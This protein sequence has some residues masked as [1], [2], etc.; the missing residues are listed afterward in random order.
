MKILK[1]VLYGI[2]IILSI[3][4]ALIFGAC[5]TQTG[6][7]LLIF[8]TSPILQHYGININTQNVFGVLAK[9]RINQFV[10]TQESEEIFVRQFQ[11]DWHPGKLIFQDSLSIESLSINKVLIH[12]IS[13]KKQAT[14]STK[15]FSF[16]ELEETLDISLPIDIS[17]K[18]ILIK[19]IN[20]AYDSTKLNL[21]KLQASLELDDRLYFANITLNGKA[22]DAVF[23]ADFGVKKVFAHAKIVSK[24]TDAPFNLEMNTDG[25]FADYRINLHT[26]FASGEYTNT[27]DLNAKGDDNKLNAKIS[28]VMLDNKFSGNA[29]IDFAHH[30]AW[31]IKLHSPHFFIKNIKTYFT[32]LSLQCNQSG[33]VQ[34][35]T[36]NVSS[37][38]ESGKV[39]INFVYKPISNIWKLEVITDKLSILN[40]PNSNLTL[41]SKISVIKTDVMRINGNINIP[42]AKV[43]LDYLKAKFASEEDV[44]FVNAKNQ[45]KTASLLAN[46]QGNIKV[47]FGNNVNLYNDDIN[48]MLS[49]SLHIIIKPNLPVVA[50]GTL[51]LKKGTYHLQTKTFTFDDGKVLFINSPISNPAL[52]ITAIYKLPPSFDLK[53]AGKTPTVIGVKVTG[54]AHNPSLELFST[55]AMSKNDILSYM[56]FGNKVKDLQS[57]SS[58]L[59]HKAL[60]ML[61]HGT[62]SLLLSNVKSSTQLAQLSVG[63]INTDNDASSTKDNSAVFIGNNLTNRIYVSYGI[64]LF[65]HQHVFTTIYK[66]NH[67]WRVKG[68]NSNDGVGVD[69]LYLINY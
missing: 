46:A 15:K 10:I 29:S 39:N 5:Y 2:L 27:L 50:N 30:D 33:W 53:N 32:N 62:G 42:K 67:N 17:A 55:P 61:L 60:S 37:K 45:K 65:N 6:F 68:T 58:N 54:T 24:Q 8:L 19:D 7:R 12:K 14:A 9:F 51:L 64:G 63:K 1:R 21:G 52:Q 28:G 56:L 11:L 25:S 59:S 34:T 66:L 57:G 44:V 35:A 20:V 47:S 49:G 43:N 41:N 23:H 13:S 36:C 4:I 26:E 22:Y 18:S 31:Q 69:L 48:T 40:M 3:C 38:F 16:E